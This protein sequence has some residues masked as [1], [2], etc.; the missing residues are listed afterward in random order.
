MA[1]DMWMLCCII[2]YSA[3]RYTEDAVTA[4]TSRGDKNHQVAFE[5]HK[6]LFSFIASEQPEAVVCCVGG[7]VVY[8][9]V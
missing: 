7:T 8:S 1:A 2:V 3:S 6:M 4:N 9:H 5:V